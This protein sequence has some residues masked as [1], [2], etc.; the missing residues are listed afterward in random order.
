MYD[1]ESILKRLEKKVG[2]DKENPALHTVMNDFLDKKE[3]YEA[4]K[5][6]EWL[7]SFL[8]VRYR[9]VHY[10][11]GS[12]KRVS[13]FFLLPG[14]GLP[15]IAGVRV[16]GGAQFELTYNPVTFLQLTDSE[17]VWVL[18][19][20]ILHLALH[21]CT[22]R[23]KD[24]QILANYAMDLAVN[25][26][27]PEEAGS[28]DAPKDKDGK[29]T[30]LKVD[31]LKKNPLYS[32]IENMQTAEWYY[33][34]LMK[35]CPPQKQG[36]NGKGK[37][38]KGNNEKE[39]GDKQLDNHTGFHEDEIADEIIREKIKEIERLNMWGRLSSTCKEAVLAAQS[40]RINWRN[41]IRRF[42]G[43]AVWKEREA[44]RKRPNR[45]TGYA[46]PGRKRI[47]L[48]RILVAVDTSGSIDS[49]LLAQFLATVNGMTDYVPIDLMQFDAD[50]TD[51]PVPFDQKK[52]EYTFTGRG[53]TNFQP[54]IDTVTERKYKAVVILT[55][56]CAAEPTKPR[57][58]VMW[59]LPR[60]CTPPV[61][62]GTRIHMDKHA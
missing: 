47:H 42:V 54:I 62:W 45:R 43:N 16:L 50:K 27:I 32:D 26:L 41:Y 48:D 12:L 10:I 39:L 9:F 4:E 21:H 25:E 61:E 34:Y 36:G 59:V 58:R 3:I 23:Q 46:Y 14:S 51:G 60:N 20:E 37:G 29:I 24:N 19:H 56:G 31:E 13:R 1:P 7:V 5:L 28:C 35:K 40:K 8:I 33:E 44:T 2:K 17:K 18:Y 49:D 38:G 11:L 30:I 52:V 55:D 22:T 53:G 6:M 15:G 57:A